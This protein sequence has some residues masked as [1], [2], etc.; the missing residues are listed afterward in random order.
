MEVNGICGNNANL[1]LTLSRGQG[2][3]TAGPMNANTTIRKNYNPVLAKKAT[4]ESLPW[5]SLGA[6][7]RNGSRLREAG[8]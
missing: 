6:K 2:H 7:P 3:A 4:P 8:E 5:T 1:P